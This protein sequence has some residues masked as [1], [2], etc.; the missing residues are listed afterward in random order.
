MKRYHYKPGDLV[1]LQNSG[2]EM[3]VNRKTKPRYLGPYEV[4]R[5][6]KGGSYIIQELDGSIL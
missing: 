6:T 1:L 5:K 4:V 2:E 3:K